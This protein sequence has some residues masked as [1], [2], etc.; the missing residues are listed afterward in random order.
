M[1][2]IS[3]HSSLPSKKTSEMI[4]SV[5]GD[6]LLVTRKSEERISCDNPNPPPIPPLMSPI[7]HTD[8]SASPMLSTH[9]NSCH[10]GLSV[11]HQDRGVS[12]DGI[13]EIAFN[14]ESGISIGV[15]SSPVSSAPEIPRTMKNRIP[16]IRNI[17]FKYIIA[18]CEIKMFRPN[19][20]VCIQ[21]KK[22]KN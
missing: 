22:E 4:S 17:R 6:E 19:T 11:I 10:R 15:N 2:E 3:S 5:M 21:T 12:Q 14:H 9:V 7:P 1:F 20:P 18:F 16:E 8:V 13:S